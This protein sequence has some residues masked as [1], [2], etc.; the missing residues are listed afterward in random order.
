MNKFTQ[1]MDTLVGRTKA[2]SEA[3]YNDNSLEELIGLVEK[4]TVDKTDCETWHITPDQWR[5]A[6]NAA[7]FALKEDARYLS[8]H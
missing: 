7:C 1:K 2:F 6:V 8:S 3:C 5:K 4:G